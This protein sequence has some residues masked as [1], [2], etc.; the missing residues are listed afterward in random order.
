MQDSGLHLARVS[1]RKASYLIRTGDEGVMPGANT[2]MNTGLVRLRIPVFSV[3]S[4]F[5]AG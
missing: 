2:V 5:A 4:V 3:T 1:R